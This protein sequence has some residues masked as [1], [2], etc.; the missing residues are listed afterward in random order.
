MNNKFFVDIILPTYN[1]KIF[2]H[3]T[4][5]SV[6]N[7]SY[8]YWRL[9]IID[10]GSTD[11]TEKILYR[12]YN[13]FKDKKKILLL[14]N[15]KNKGQAFSRNLGLRNTKSK[16]I[17]FLDSDDFWSKNKLKKQIKFMIS[18]TYDLTYTDYK[19][20]KN[21]KIKTVRVPDYFNYK[22]FIHNSS[23]TTSSVIL[24][25]KI[26]KNIYF[27]NLKFLEDYFFKCQIL[28][29]NVKAYRCPGLYTY[30]LIRND[31]LQS[32]RFSVLISLWIINKNLN[33]M[34]FINNI[35]SILSILF[36]SLKKYGFR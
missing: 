19:I 31:S 26:I 33:K 27:R 23:I 36:N 2:I 34:N 22:K 24:K 11:G 29:K 9:I 1:S 4:I 10:D 8:K 14:R 21:H 32:N 3:K 6:F 15:N 35:V 12:L 28:K 13:K 7:Q 16:F 5:K 18:N 20:I 25:K 30:Y 17:A